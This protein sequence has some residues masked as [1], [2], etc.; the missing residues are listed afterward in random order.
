MNIFS[1]IRFNIY[2]IICS[3]IFAILLFAYV[4]IGAINQNSIGFGVVNS[5]NEVKENIYLARLYKQDYILLGDPVIAERFESKYRQ[6]VE[7][8]VE[9]NGEYK[10]HVSD[11]ELMKARKLLDGFY[12]TFQTYNELTEELEVKTKEFS[13]ISLTLIETIELLL[14]NDSSIFNDIEID[15]I[16]DLKDS[17]V[18]VNV[19]IP[20]SQWVDDYQLNFDANVLD[21]VPEEHR[22]EIKQ[23]ISSLNNILSS[24]LRIKSSMKEDQNLGIDLAIKSSQALDDMAEEEKLLLMKTSEQ[25]TNT[26]YIYLVGVLVFCTFAAVYLI[27]KIYKPIGGEPKEIERIVES[28]ASG[29]LSIDSEENTH[30]AL[31]G[32]Y[33]SVIRMSSNLSSVVE[34]IISSSNS[35]GELAKQ[36]RENSMETKGV[37]NLQAEQIECL[38][39]SMTQV[40]ST[41]E[42]IARNAQMTAESTTDAST[43]VKEVVALTERSN[44]LVSDLVSQVGM[45]K[46]RMTELLDESNN[47]ATILDVIKSITEQTNL[48]ALNAAIEA[49]RAGDA[50]RGFAVVADEVR[51]LALKTQE[52]TEQ[53]NALILGLQTK[54][55]ETNE[56]I[57]NTQD[58]ATGSI[59]GANASLVAMQNIS[60]L[61]ESISDMNNQVATAAEQQNVVVQSVNANLHKVQELSTKALRCSETTYDI[62][63]SLEDSSNSM[64]ASVSHFTLAKA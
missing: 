64:H 3:V 23:K 38:I 53:I 4:V 58:M 33:S 6:G 45:A 41:V 27:R 56:L 37:S 34:S 13:S 15:E 20:N 47:I 10:E 30:G 12:R 46:V 59:E 42:E 28:V 60:N 9:L 8:L 54:A 61:T 7:K 25:T 16:F 62:S 39:T 2:L 31:T 55:A 24:T 43:N 35:T 19:L 32:V 36:V 14:E 49:A 52:S 22:Q 21:K 44:E 17:I 50:G 1:S 29:D 48:L 26:I 40:S 5:M 51:L 11:A 57:N 18:K 63:E